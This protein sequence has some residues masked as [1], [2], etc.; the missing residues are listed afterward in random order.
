M[1]QALLAVLALLWWAGA[2]LGQTEARAV[3]DVP[4]GEA[5]IRG[6]VVHGDPATVADA[7]MSGL[8]VALYALGQ[9]GRAG[10]RETETDADGAFRFDGVSNAPD[11]AYVVG[12]RYRGVP[13]GERAAFAPDSPE[14]EL[15]IRVEEPVTSA[16]ALEM[17]ETELR[18]DWI[19]GALAVQQLH[20]VKNGGSGVVYVAPDDRDT[21]PAPF[22][23]E[24]P[25]GATQFTPAL[26]AFAGSFEERGRRLFYWGPFYPGDQEV[27]FLYRLPVT[28]DPKGEE[29]PLRVAFPAGATRLTVL[30]P[31][32]GLEADLPGAD[33]GEP[34]ERD[35]QRYR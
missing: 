9:D 29:V 13:F 25:E 5:S 17:G 15:V 24:L 34:V 33:A 7:D 4:A 27:S 6:T 11:L 26:G 16:R 22:E 12:T 18:I 3:P 23:T 20:R 28:G 19:G 8:T 14:L 1:R 31:D 35:G 2:A 21:V 32:S 10:L 30:V